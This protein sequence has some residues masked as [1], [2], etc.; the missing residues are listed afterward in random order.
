MW[1]EI[2]RE[3]SDSPSQSRVARFLL[4]NGF[5]VNEQGRVVC[6]DIE[7][8]STHIAKAIGTDR[9]VVDATVR[10]VLSQPNLHDVFINLRVTPDLSR[11]GAALDL[12]VI[13]V[14]PKDASEKGIVGAV[15][16]VLTDHNLGIRQIFV[17]DPMLSEEP[18]L[19]VIVD[20]RLPPVV[21]EKLKSLM[22]VRQLII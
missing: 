22:Q 1:A 5:G 9:R 12:T 21:Y 13:T 10:R 17:T 18:R 6:N 19:V 11:V 15:V 7:I 4:E 3:F 16:K 2:L 14:L 8:P 20:K